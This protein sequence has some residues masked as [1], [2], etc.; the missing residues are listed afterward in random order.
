[1][2]CRT[3]YRYRQILLLYIVEC[4]V[5]REEEK[6]HG[7][8]MAYRGIPIPPCDNDRLLRLINSVDELNN[9]D[10]LPHLLKVFSENEL[11]PVTYEPLIDL[12]SI[13]PVLLKCDTYLQQIKHSEEFGSE[14]ESNILQVLEFLSAMLSSGKHK[15]YFLGVKA[16]H[17]LLST[18]ISTIFAK[19]LDVIYS[20]CFQPT[21]I[22]KYS[23]E[24][25]WAEATEVPLEIAHSVMAI[26]EG[27]GFFH[28]QYSL[29]DHLN[30]QEP[31]LTVS[32][33]LDVLIKQDGSSEECRLQIPMQMKSSIQEAFN[34]I[35]QTNTSLNHL[36]KL[37]L[38]SVLLSLNSLKE[39][40]R[41]REELVQ[42]RLKCLH[43]LLCSQIS[44]EH[45]QIYFGNGNSILNDLVY[46]C[47]VSQTHSYSGDKSTLSMLSLRCVIALI[48]SSLYRRRTLAKNY[49]IL[50][51]LGIT[52]A[53][54][55]SSLTGSPHEIRWITIVMAIITKFSSRMSEGSHF[56][57]ANSGNL[58][59]L[60]CI[61][62]EFELSIKLL[63]A[64]LSIQEYRVVSES[65][66]LTA[67]IGSIHAF[68]ENLLR[69]NSQRTEIEL[70][71]TSRCIN[72]IGAAIQ[73][74]DIALSTHI[75]RENIFREA[76]GIDL[77]TRLFDVIST[78]YVPLYDKYGTCF[79][80]L[81]RRSLELL[82]TSFR[83][84]RRRLRSPAESGIQIV[85]HSN[86]PSLFSFILG[87][88]KDTNRC[89][90]VAAYCFLL[91][92]AIDLE[93]QF[94]THCVNCEICV[95]LK[96]VMTSSHNSPLVTA[97]SESS[98]SVET[99]ILSLFDLIEAFAIT[100]EGK[101]FLESSTI[102]DSILNVVVRND[103]TL[104]GKI[105]RLSPDS[106]STIG[107]YI[108]QIIR[109][110]EFLRNLIIDHLRNNFIKFSREV[111]NLALY[112]NPESEG[113]IQCRLESITDIAIV[114]DS[115]G[116]VV[117]NRFHSLNDY[118]VAFFT[119]EVFEAIDILFLWSVSESNVLFSQLCSCLENNFNKSS[120]GDHFFLKSL[121]S[122]LLMGMN[123][124][125][126]FAMPVLF[127]SIDNCLIDL[128]KHIGS[129]S[130]IHR[131]IPES[132]WSPKNVNIIGLLDCIPDCLFEEI[133]EMNVKSAISNVMRLLM[134]L[135]W[136][137]LRLSDCFI[138]SD[139]SHRGVDQTLMTASKDIMKRLYAFVRFSLL[140]ISRVGG[141]SW[142][143]E[144]ISKC[145]HVMDLQT[146]SLSNKYSFN[147]LP[148]KPRS[149]Q[150]KV[151]NSAGVLLKDK[152]N[153]EGACAVLLLPKGATIE[154]FNRQTNSTGQLRYQTSFGWLSEY[155]SET[156]PNVVIENITFSDHKDS[157]QQY[158]TLQDSFI[159]CL[160]QVLGSVRLLTTEL[161]QAVIAESSSD[162][163]YSLSRK[164]G[165][166]K[167][168]PLMS[169]IFVK[170][171]TKFFENP[172][173]LS[174]N[175]SSIWLAGLKNDIVKES[176]DYTDSS[177]NASQEK[178]L[179]TKKSG[180]SNYN[181]EDALKKGKKKDGAEAKNAHTK[182]SKKEKPAIK[183][184][185]Q[186]DDCDSNFSD[187]NFSL[188]S[189][190]L[191]LASTIKYVL[192]PLI[193]T[194]KNTF[195]TYMWKQLKENSL[196]K[197]TLTSF[198]SLIRHYDGILD[199]QQFGE[200]V[201]GEILC[202]LYSLKPYLQFMQQV[203]SQKYILK[204]S[205]T[206]LLK[207]AESDKG[208][209]IEAILESF[210]TDVAKSLFAL[211][212]DASFAGLP[213][214]YQNKILVMYGEILEALQSYQKPESQKNSLKSDTFG[215]KSSLSAAIRELFSFG[216]V[217]S[218]RISGSDDY[219]DSQQIVQHRDS[220]SSEHSDDIQME[221]LGLIESS[222]EGSR[223]VAEES[224]DIAQQ[225]LPF[226]QEPMPIT[227][228]VPSTTSLQR[229]DLL[230]AQDS[231]AV[232][233]CED[234]EELM[235]AIK[236]S[237]ELQEQ[238]KKEVESPTKVTDKQDSPQVVAVSVLHEYSA[239][240]T[241]E[242]FF[243]NIWRHTLNVLRLSNVKIDN[244]KGVDWFVF[245]TKVFQN[246]LPIV[247]SKVLKMLC[248]DKDANCFLGS[249]LFL[250]DL[251]KS[252]SL[253]W[254]SLSSSEHDSAAISIIEQ[255]INYFDKRFLCDL[256]TSL[257]ENDAVCFEVGYLIVSLWLSSNPTVLSSQSCCHRLF[258][259]C[260][261]A[262]R[263]LEINMRTQDIVILNRL[264]KLCSLFI[265]FEEYVQQFVDDGCLSRLFSLK[266]R[267]N[268]ESILVGLEKSTL[269]VIL[270]RC[271]ETKVIL[272]NLM[273]LEIR[274]IFQE[275]F[276]IQSIVESKD[277]LVKCSHLISRDKPL[278][279]DVIKEI[280]RKD[281]KSQNV[282]MKKSIDKESSINLNDGRFDKV[283]H[284]VLLQF[285]RDS[286]NFII[287]NEQILD[288][289]TDCVLVILDIASLLLIFW[290]EDAKSLDK[291]V[292]DAI[293]SL[294]IGIRQKSS[295]LLVVLCHRKGQLRHLILDRI[296]LLLRQ[297]SSL[298]VYDCA[299]YSRIARL[300]QV[301]S[302]VIGSWK[303]V[304]ESS[305][306][307]RNLKCHL[308]SNA[309]QYLWQNDVP[310]IFI[311]LLDLIQSSPAQAKKAFM[312]ICSFLEIL[313]RPSSIALW[314]KDLKALS[315]KGLA[316]EKS[317]DNDAEGRER[318]ETFEEDK[319][320]EVLGDTDETSYE[321][322]QNEDSPGGVEII[323]DENELSQ[324]EQD[325]DG[326]TEEVEED[327]EDY[328]EEEEDEIEEM[329]DEEEN[330]TQRT[331]PRLPHLGIRE[332]IE[333]ALTSDHDHHNIYVTPEN[334]ARELMN[335]SMGNSNFLPDLDADGLDHHS[336]F[337]NF[338]NDA[339][340]R[341]LGRS[342]H[343]ISNS[344]NQRT[345][346]NV[347]QEDTVLSGGLEEAFR[348]DW[349]NADATLLT[350]NP[351]GERYNSS[352]A[353]WASFPLPSI[354]ADTI[355]DISSHIIPEAVDDN[356]NEEMK[357]SESAEA[358]VAS[359][360][361]QINAICKE[362]EKVETKECC[363]TNCT[364]IDDIVIS[365]DTDENNSS[366]TENA[367]DAPVVSLTGVSQQQMDSDPALQIEALT[368]DHALSSTSSQSIELA[369]PTIELSTA[370]FDNGTS[371]QSSEESPNLINDPP[372]FSEDGAILAPVFIEQNLTTSEVAVG[373][374]PMIDEG[375]NNDLQISGL[376][377]PPGY[378]PE[379]FSSLPD[380]M[381]QEIIDQHNETNGNTREILEEAGYDFD[382]F[383]ALPENI[384]QEILDQATR[385]RQSRLDAE[386]RN[387]QPAEMDNSSFLTSLTPELRAE[388]LLTADSAFIA[389]LT[390]E[391]VAEAQMLRDRAAA[392]WQ[393]IELASS[394]QEQP[395]MEEQQHAGR[396]LLGSRRRIASRYE[397]S[398]E[399][400]VPTASKAVVQF[401]YKGGKLKIQ[402]EIKDY[403]I[404]H[405]QLTFIFRYFYF[406][407]CTISSTKTINKLLENLSRVAVYREEIVRNFCIFLAGNS[408]G[409]T[410][411]LCY[412]C[413]KSNQL[414][415]LINQ[416]ETVPTQVLIQLLQSLNYLCL[417]NPSVLLEMLL[418]RKLTEMNWICDGQEKADETESC[419]YEI[420]IRLLQNVTILLN[421]SNMQ[422]VLKSI[423]DFAVPLTHV[424]EQAGGEDEKDILDSLYV[425]IPKVRIS[426]SGLRSL[427]E[428]LLSDVCTKEVLDL[429]INAITKLSSI[430]VNK[431][432]LID[433]IKEVIGEIGSQAITKF[434]QFLSQ[435][436]HLN[437]ADVTQSNVISYAAEI[438][439]HIQSK[440]FRSL[441]TLISL[442]SEGTVLD[443]LVP[444]DDLIPMWISLDKILTKLESLFL[445][446]ESSK[447]TQKTSVIKNHMHTGLLSV[448]Y[449]FLP[450]IE[451]CFVAY[452][453]GL[454]SSLSQSGKV[455]A[456]D[457]QDSPSKAG[458][459][460]PLLSRQQSNTPGAK[461]RQSQTFAQFNVSLFRLDSKDAG[462]DNI[463]PS[464]SL[465]TSK[466]LR[467]QST[468][469]LNVNFSNVFSYS[470][471]LGAFVQ[472]HRNLLNILIKANPQLLES[473]LQGLIRI[474]QLRHFLVFDAKRTYFQNE[475]KKR[476]SSRGQR[477]IHLQIRRDNIFEDSFYQLRSRTADELKGKLYINFHEEE[478]IDAGGLTREWYSV[479]SREVFNPNYCLFTPAF[480]G[481]TFQ[482]N[483]LS[484][485]NS[486]HLDYFKFVGRVIGK[487]V[488]D[489]H[490]MDGHFTRSFYKHIL[491]VPIDYTDIEGV[492]PE[493]YKSLKQILEFSLSDLG[494][495]LTFSTDV[496]SFGKYEVVDLIP[497]GKNIPVTDLNKM[498]Y[499]RLISHHIMTSAI[500][501]QIE[502]FLEGFY[503]LVPP[504]LISIF[505]PTEL[506]LL[507]CGLPDIDIEDLANN[508]E[509]HQYLPTDQNIVWFWEA[510]N[511]FSR[512]E[513]ALFVQFVTGTSKVP[514]EGFASLQGIRGPQKFS[515]HKAYTSKSSLPTAHT[516]FNQLDLPEY[517][518]YEELR[519]KLLIAIKEGS[520]GFGFA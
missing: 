17:E 359:N 103:E 479:L 438:D 486:N 405:T 319:S 275:L 97:F 85:Y 512:E 404:L 190:F 176:V 346:Q 389:S 377:C 333:S 513:R 30:G 460:P 480:D 83:Q 302:L 303:S 407:D 131:G 171:V 466:S 96:T 99:L 45:L 332:L 151:V 371:P 520:E 244:M 456:A 296:V 308:S 264:L 516:C 84:A 362:E 48:E 501:S 326:R 421:A 426:K 463:P 357:Y 27:L 418:P 388:V 495:E 159:F 43:I 462:S 417:A 46:F 508:T 139:R 274:S 14:Q 100:N 241:S 67:L 454:L 409:E 173:P 428:A 123:R 478:G 278:F 196:F 237:C 215:K 288:S 519:D 185:F 399:T 368:V 461:Y 443:T 172:C 92:S 370:T 128:S 157:D 432:A 125:P 235:A 136:L 197:F 222:T 209:Q 253:F 457:K 287:K 270:R 32:N 392:R 387:V 342:A 12:R 114:V 49:S 210:L 106:F 60:D 156:S 51:E 26:F 186:V 107:R 318:T 474:P 242:V 329:D 64:A 400:N 169:S 187:F 285:D 451:C 411:F 175:L 135:D 19:S 415:S 331:L 147:R 110:V 18:F 79:F 161:A 255:L 102:L 34:H 57:G 355:S 254:K 183:Q 353:G 305:I 337:I 228:L 406:E 31:I 207:S 20:Y 179:K 414:I 230:N 165:I 315:K 117:N 344:R 328:D 430:E 314:V 246:G 52:K 105:I 381:Q 402:K 5:D 492:E 394:N 144:A 162:D 163:R 298:N 122:L 141:K 383:N 223:L 160:K 252:P 191:Y 236:L 90:L 507:I 231:L 145:D 250:S 88:A 265:T 468:D 393:R 7:S 55:S 65:S 323:G 167:I 218:S 272:R 301:L 385:E 148:V 73:S 68:V 345:V 180:K 211:F 263:V 504:E 284:D 89:I 39:N 391:L 403:G 104:Y 259:C 177:D 124:V 126:Q 166:S 376:L 63:S 182:K 366:N 444:H 212:K 78:Q 81:V 498:D 140:E 198:Q 206:S 482:P 47:D 199:K 251:L 271:F 435:I 61:V 184:N 221:E 9:I 6:I 132:P 280:V 297:Q 477:S 447:G 224:S 363:E 471:Q 434:E 464:L 35:C 134:K 429:V 44:V 127:K 113:K 373:V 379:V 56:S 216:S 203:T 431:V 225:E 25:D 10:G 248:E 23:I 54:S 71:F 506:E 11:K 316:R 267:D 494:L 335:S 21:R 40:E 69:V 354:S 283:L 361:L 282:V 515:I 336:S 249:I 408:T 41:S 101:A 119:T 33:T 441:N 286:T 469:V 4:S 289:L 487:A 87:Q 306:A 518:S 476:K 111:V 279:E 510:I 310:K 152:L 66:A 499:V 374:D 338:I 427:C 155:Q 195:N 311:R 449:K 446:Q 470:Q 188:S 384:R 213:I 452:T 396:G 290:N 93:P 489:G 496:Q 192:T 112:Q 467:N 433:V 324:N 348:A 116:T 334:I 108:G 94:L 500:R 226:S 95:T 386:M 459:A 13:F 174:E 229:D 291:I 304:K 232:T 62:E 281:P 276:T 317:L 349:G 473:S 50:N 312:S 133:L 472:T 257:N 321:D 262:L 36:Q 86:F 239:T 390:P 491:G 412:N 458:D 82:T 320:E 375:G 2:E 490:L 118:T 453:A 3:L 149:F 517:S 164:T 16:V 158:G 439:L 322:L 205:I 153:S 343:T 115:I 401:D 422:I 307:E 425:P 299:F 8:T 1:M 72:A 138:A 325:E 360:A 214:T 509:Y 505:S 292:E 260:L 339:A 53:E 365:V 121:N 268:T 277:L 300:A 497:G 493:F 397:E 367:V 137:C 170:I 442:A 502:S 208:N 168:A 413:S 309:L 382:T 503:D 219:Q 293:C 76:E 38:Y 70:L 220:I 475:L 58:E 240:L 269:S 109:D 372:A 261:N 202:C 227:S 369:V 22:E 483:P 37:A 247:F 29:L 410:P 341:S 234:D 28:P 395:G 181:H 347:N 378:D 437:S 59:A 423:N 440:L 313:T 488:V 258:L 352:P 327:E 351:I 273:V 233:E 42:L 204:S 130:N 398:K 120:I 15:R 420:V 511:T 330:E 98:E 266:R 450:S 193:G 356:D 416:Q 424:A 142:R 238:C 178:Q 91:A 364:N 189:M 256:T 194:S 154:A 380:F 465:N 455:E 80:V 448:L 146:F 75:N 24:I 201:D 77:L 340:R 445:V 481:A 243:H 419:F 150:L 350:S 129:L 294:D 295:R 200:I 484:N 143:P 485:I 358:G 245:L 74:V 514:L 436:Q 217:V